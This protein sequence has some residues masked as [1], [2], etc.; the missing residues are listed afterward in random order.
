MLNSPAFIAYARP[1][2]TYIA[3]GRKM[4]EVEARFRESGADGEGFICVDEEGRSR[5]LWIAL[6]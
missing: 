6:P 3:T 4:S 5:M 2:G 1:F